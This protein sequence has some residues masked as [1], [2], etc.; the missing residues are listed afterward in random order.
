LVEAQRGSDTREGRD[1]RPTLARSPFAPSGASANSVAEDGDAMAAIASLLEDKEPEVRAADRHAVAMMSDAGYTAA[2]E[3]LGKLLADE[4][5]RVRSLAGVA[6]AKLGTPAQFDA[7]VQ[8]AEARDDDADLFLRHA[9]AMAL[10]GSG[11]GKL[12]ELAKHSSKAV[13]L[14]AVVAARAM[15]RDPQ[16]EAFLA[17]RGLGRRRRSCPRRHS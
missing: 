11:K 2:A 6:L 9:A 15:N 12:G 17:R 4:S 8:L 13:R 14:A 10:S 16:A 5:P 7:A 1:Q 3:A